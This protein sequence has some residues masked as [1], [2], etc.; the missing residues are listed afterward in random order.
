MNNFIKR[1]ISA[2]V[3][4][5]ILYLIAIIPQEKLIFLIIAIGI[6]AIFELNKNFNKK[7]AKFYGIANIY[8]AFGIFSMH[9]FIAENSNLEFI[10]VLAIIIS[11]DSF[12]YITGKIIGGPK[13][14]PKIS[15]NKTFAGLFGGIISAF[16]VGILIQTFCETSL[17]VK[18]IAII[19]TFSVIGDLVASMFKRKVEIKDFSNLIPGHGGILDRIDSIILVSIAL[20]LYKILL[21]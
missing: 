1:S 2:F 5:P 11:T 12:A 18:T 21:I 9:H 6:A 19:I 20:Y 14:C 15:P 3:M 8:V 13:M 16:C 17:S 4:L 10:F 7:Y